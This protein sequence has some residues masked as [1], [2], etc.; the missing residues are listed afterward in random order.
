MATQGKVKHREIYEHI[1]HG[2]VSGRFAVGDR[3]PTETEL[4]Q[5]FNAS[6]VT[7]ARALRDLEQ[8]GLLIRRRGAGTFVS[9]RQS[10]KAQLLGLIS[11]DTPGIFSMITDSLARL[12]HD[13]GLGLLLGRQLT[14]DAG[15]LKQDVDA[16]CEQYIHRK[17]AG[18]FFSPIDAAPEIASL[19]HRIADALEKARIPVVLLDRD[20]S[21][22]PCRSRFDLVGLDNVHAGY[23]LAEHLIGLGYRRIV[24]PHPD[25]RVSTVTA[26]IAGYHEA[27]RAHGIACDPTWTALGDNTDVDFVRGLLRR[28]KADAMICVNDHDAAK[29]MRSLAA[30]SVNVPGDLALVGV[31]DDRWATYLSVALTTLR[32]PCSEIASAAMTLMLERMARP[33]LPAREICLA[34][35]LIVRESCGASLRGLAPSTSKP[36]GVQAKCNA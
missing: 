20:I 15:R 25:R 14:G 34:G 18:V 24:F 33:S 4:S 17:V 27:L 9:Q 10:E 1:H 29:M 32:Q 23:V 36:T 28:T 8:Q 16:L 35:E 21:D 30:L 2:I 3:I 11:P 5:Q 7:V 12:A 13:N 31:D 22:F 6:R 26:R 19:N